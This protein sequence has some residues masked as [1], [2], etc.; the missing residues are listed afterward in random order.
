MIARRSKLNL[1]TTNVRVGRQLNGLFPV[2]GEMTA[3]AAANSSACQDRS[4]EDDIYIVTMLL[5]DLGFHLEQGKLLICTKI[6]L[7]TAKKYPQ[8]LQNW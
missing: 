5:L 2:I 6:P 1:C 4:K 8:N 3:M 7:E